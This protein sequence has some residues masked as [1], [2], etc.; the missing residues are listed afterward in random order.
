MG[1]AGQQY[2]GESRC[3]GMRCIHGDRPD[4]K[5]ANMI[6]DLACKPPGSAS[7]LVVR[8]G[9]FLSLSCPMGVLSGMPVSGFR[10]SVVRTSD[11]S[12]I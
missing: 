11:S 7:R 12:G 9:L 1:I 6:A 10:K 4:L 5:S 2:A 8:Q 3:C